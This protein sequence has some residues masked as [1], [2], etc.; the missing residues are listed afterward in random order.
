MHFPVKIRPSL[1]IACLNSAAHFESIGEIK[2][3]FN[4]IIEFWNG[5]FFRQYKEKFEKILIG[6]RD[7]YLPLG[8]KK[9]LDTDVLI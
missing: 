9:V 7:K 5:K 6:T 3:T 4:I 2:Y 1:L 8:Q